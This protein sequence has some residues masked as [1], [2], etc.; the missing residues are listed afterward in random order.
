MSKREVG[1]ARGA[2][3]RF[4]EKGLLLQNEAKTKPKRSQ[5]EAKS[6]LILNE[7]RIRRR[8]RGCHLGIG[9]PDRHRIAAQ[10]LLHIFALVL[11]WGR[12]R[13]A[14]S[15]GGSRLS[16]RLVPFAGRIFGTRRA[17]QQE[18][19]V[20]KNAASPPGLAAPR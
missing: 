16:G 3:A 18:D 17:V 4:E 12:G 13:G 11:V 6:V 19:K 2:Q 5:N 7:G 10:E 9:A 15:P 8:Q 1:D 14:A 20:G